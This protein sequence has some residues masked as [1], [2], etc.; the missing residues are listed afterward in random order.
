MIFL[1]ADHG[2]YVAKQMLCA[3]LEKKG[4]TYTDLGA[5]SLEPNDDYPA[6]AHTV[7]QKVLESTENR[8]VLLCRTGS[9]MVMAA[10][11]SKGI[12]AVE[13]WSSEIVRLSRTHNDA[14]I[15][16]LSG[17]FLT[18][19]QME[20]FTDL[21]LSTSFLHETRHV[22]RIAQIDSLI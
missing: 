19:D 3:Y 9:G 11:R 5:H 6:I 8:G 20:N 21:F 1:G 16:S 2:G 22:R 13:G 7:A 14:N 18:S 17:D 15:L 12:R 4:I 10:N